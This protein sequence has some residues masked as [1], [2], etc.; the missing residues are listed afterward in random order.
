MTNYE[1]PKRIHYLDNLRA[2]A[3]LV[4]A[5]DHALH[6]YAQNFA[7]FWFFKDYERSELF[8]AFYLFDQT[9]IMPMLFLIAGTFAYEAASKRSVFAF[10]KERAV[11]L[12]I[13]FAVFIPLTVP[14]LSFPRY[15]TYIQPGTSFWEFWSQIFF[16]ERLQAGPLWVMQAMFMFSLI[17][18]LYYRVLPF[19]WSFVIVI[20]QWC[21][22]NKILAVSLFIIKSLIYLWVCDV[23]WGAPWW[24]NLSGVFGIEDWSLWNS[25]WKLFSYQGGRFL[26]ILMYFMAGAA[27]AAMDAFRDSDFMES[28]ANKWAYFLS[29]MVVCAVCY[30]GFSMYFMFDGAFDDTTS[31]LIRG[32]DHWTW[33]QLWNAIQD[34]SQLPAIRTSLL[35]L[36]TFTQVSFLL[37]F[38][39]RFVSKPTPIW[40]FLS[41]NAYGFF[42]VHETLMVWSQYMLNDIELPTIFKFM[43]TLIFGIAGGFY[44]SNL[45]L[46]VPVFK[47]ILSPDDPR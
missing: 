14:L 38:F 27:L 37:A 47:R 10:I 5:F 36:L 22:R 19:I 7:Q 32:D 18:I 8:D 12:M 43:I 3:F 44:I 45:M 11:R 24:F 29:A 39:Y 20:M 42:L 33:L 21:M 26:L 23:I 16:Q 2:F 31:R 34:H 28:I 6:A 15:E 35:G 4:M 41:A 17:F 40:V 9:L 1:S 46:K 13:P 25:F 30:V